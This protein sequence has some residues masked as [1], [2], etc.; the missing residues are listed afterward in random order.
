VLAACAVPIR[1]NSYVERG[2][3]LR[4][5]RTFDFA[6]ADAVPTGDPRLDGNPF[7]QERVRAAVETHLGTRGYER[8]AAGT[9]DFRVHVHV[10]VVQDI[11]VNEIDQ[12]NGYCAPGV[13]RPFVYEAGTL[14]L[15]LVDAHTNKLLW[16]GWAESH[17]DGVVDN[18][19]WMEQ[20]IDVAVAKIMAKVPRHPQGRAS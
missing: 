15:D 12:P 14:L 18:Q 4:R 1:V 11:D 5:Y 7:F 13:C 8:T 10:S 6:P 16:R 9:P 17:I 3:D 2:A 20:R 19:A